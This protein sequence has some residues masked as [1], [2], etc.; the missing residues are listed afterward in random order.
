MSGQTKT[1]AAKHGQMVG[2]R[3][4]RDEHTWLKKTAKLA[5]LP[6]ATYVRMAVLQKMRDA[7]VALEEE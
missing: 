4:T 2:I 6:V 1:A 7:A 3:F 5:F